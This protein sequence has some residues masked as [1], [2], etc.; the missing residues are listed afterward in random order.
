MTRF[1][2]TLDRAVDLVLFALNTMVGGEIFIPKIPSFRLDDLVEAMDLDNM[3]IIGKR[4]GEKDHESLIGV[5][6]IHLARSFPDHYILHPT[7]SWHDLPD[8]G[9]RVDH[10]YT[11]HNNPWYLSVAE[12]KEELKHV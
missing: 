3:R 12:L 4:P 6:E 11:S 10:P 7:Y 1:W 8:V 9:E 2:M 5:D